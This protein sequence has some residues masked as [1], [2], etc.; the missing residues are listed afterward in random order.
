MSMS[1]GEIE[2][3]MDLVAGL[4][5]NERLAP[6]E[7]LVR[8]ADENGD[9]ELRFRARLTLVEATNHTAARHRMFAPFVY[10]LQQY[11]DG[12]RWITPWDRQRVLWLH[13][14]MVSVLAQHPQ[15]PLAQ[16]E[17]TLDGMRRRY[18]AAGE[19][20]APV[21]GCAFELQEH[22]YG[23][24][25]AEREFN[26][27]RR[28]RRTGLSDCQGC[29]PTTRIAHLAKLGRHQEAR[30]EL[31]AVLRGDLECSE[32]PHSAIA[33]ALA[34]LVELGDVETAAAL[35]RTAYRASR[36]N[37]AHTSAVAQH[38][39]VLA[40]CGN[41]GRGLDVLAEQ[42][43]ALDRP[44]TPFAGMELAAAAARLLQRVV[45]G[46]DADLPVRGPGR[47]PERA[48]DLLVRVREQAL[49][50]ASRFDERNGTTAVSAYVQQML[51]APDLPTLPL[52]SVG[53]PPGE[54]V[55]LPDLPDEP[56]VPE[57][58]R[59]A[60]L[61]GLDVVA[62]ATRAELARDFAA[63]PTWRR[64][65]AHWAARRDDALAG[66]GTSPDAVADGAAAARVRAAAD[67]EAFAAWSAEDPQPELTA[68]AA[69]LYRQVG[70]EGDA[71][72]VELRDSLR[73]GRDVDAE[74]VLAAIDATGPLGHRARVRAL[75]A[76]ESPAGRAAE[77]VAQA[78]A[79]LTDAPVTPNER[80]LAA[81][82]HLEAADGAPPEA[83]L[84]QALALLGDAPAWDVRVHVESERAGILADAGDLAGA[85]AALDRAVVIAQRAGSRE[86]VLRTEAV[87]CRV[88]AAA[89]E[90]RD[91]EARAL[92]VASAALDLDMPDV[93]ITCRML[94]AHLMA[95][96]GR[97]VEA[98]ELAEATL[99]LPEPARDASRARQRYRTGQ[100]VRLLDLASE[101]S[102]ALDEDDRAVALAREAAELADGDDALAAPAL[103]RLAGLVADADAVEATRLYG[104]ALAAAVASG[105]HA[106]GLVVRRE[107]AGARL[108]ADGLEAAL[109]DVED[110]ARAN[111]A[112]AAQALVD[113]AVATDLGE[114]DEPL[115]QLTLATLTAR[116][117][118]AVGEHER[119]LGALE[120]LAE[121]WTAMG[122]D[123]EAID[124][125]V[126]R[127]HALLGLGRGD[128][129]LAVLSAAA[130]RARSAG[131]LGLARD[132]AGAGAVWLDEEGRPRE[133]EK[134]WKR[135]A[136]ADDAG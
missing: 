114:W 35:H 91:A 64:L 5:E 100:R 85:H 45:A 72:L 26:A 58:R 106:L 2:D 32:Q 56:E 47:A 115:E 119:A 36:R 95:A 52:G 87:R 99:A 43:D 49:E 127:G 68:S 37:P 38:L 51:T 82:L 80:R 108:A 46:G 28:A 18:K 112:I 63:E 98:V 34:S 74:A 39:H 78:Q 92:A 44:S 76:D 8:A 17:S 97:P 25:G 118:M 110:A 61:A 62:L 93:V 16:L 123:G 66:L 10:V 69:R 132:A 94:A 20:M 9:P 13:K 41:V 53:S 101:L 129:G 70:A 133:A 109:R 54:V 117:L 113:P 12:A 124:V 134:F 125:D 126:L 121:R 73:A 105:Q 7:E 89:G 90:A 27:W 136:P 33:E 30:D 65:A 23:A 59:D 48:A 57:L 116:L 79:L 40:R 111:E 1:R 131:L 122:G 96:Y 15:V 31:E 120:G 24:A 81:Q 67:L 50:T 60:D 42:L 130:L 22:R 84:E 3:L 86:L 102:A 6:A 103:Y 128:D 77:L 14:W 11:D 88:L 75:L 104:R 4:P 55:R 83:V 135:H 29:E 107:R 71:L 21:L 19:G